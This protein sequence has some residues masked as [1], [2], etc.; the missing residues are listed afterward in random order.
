[1]IFELFVI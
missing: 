1:V